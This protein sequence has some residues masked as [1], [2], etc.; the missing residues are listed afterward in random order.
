MKCPKC[1]SENVQ[2]QPKEYKPKLTVPI[3]MVGGGLGLRFG[4]IIGAIIGLI[5]G[6]VVAGIAHSLLLDF[7]TN[8]K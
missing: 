5:I 2:V 7:N 8:L 4:G 1:N 6:A 3:L